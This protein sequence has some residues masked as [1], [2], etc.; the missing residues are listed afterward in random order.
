MA[1]RA[2][3]LVLAAL[4][5]RLNERYLAAKPSNGLRI[6]RRASLGEC[7]A[8]ILSRCGS[9]ERVKHIAGCNAIAI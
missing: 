9:C 3:H 5:D 2:G 4:P 6:L 7:G 1:A 8:P